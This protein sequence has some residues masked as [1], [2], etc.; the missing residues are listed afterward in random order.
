MAG[1]IGLVFGLMV[2]HF[3]SNSYA[4]LVNFQNRVQILYFRTFFHLAGY[5]SKADGVVSQAE[6]RAT[7]QIFAEMELTAEAKRQ[8]ID[9]FKEG[10]RL[11]FDLEDELGQLYQLCS[12]QPGLLRLFIQSLFSVARVDGIDA[13]KRSILDK[14]CAILGFQ[15]SNFYQQYDDAQQQSH[16]RQS[17]EQAPP[18][19]VNS[20]YALLEVPRDVS[21][22]ALKQAY[23]RLMSQH[24]PD[25]LIAKGLPESM[26]KMATQKTQQIQAAYERIKRAKGY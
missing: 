19:P 23:R 8:A 7:E 15:S 12:E 9:Y 3:V 10:Q 4:R 14:T 26:V 5:I 25:K 13:K 24:H 1:P 22:K 16:R 11:A 17:F 21:A 2:G 18:D 20:D 6:I